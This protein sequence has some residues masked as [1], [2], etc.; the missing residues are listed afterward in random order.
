MAGS[1]RWYTYEADDANVFAVRADKSNTEAANGGTDNV[2][3][4]ADSD[5][6][7]PRNIVP[8]YA[9][10]ANESGTRIIRCIILTAARYTA[11]T[12][13]STITDP[14]TSASTLTLIRK[15][16]ERYRPLPTASDTGQSSP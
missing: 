14:I 8:R 16:P 15:T 2:W 6:G 4:S 11:L 5:N 1:V 9:Y 12:G 13:G 10:Y 3:T 7:I